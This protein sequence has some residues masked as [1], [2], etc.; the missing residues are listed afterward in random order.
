[1]FYLSSLNLLQYG[2]K[3]LYM[4]RQDLKSGLYIH[5]IDVD[6]VPF[7]TPKRQNRWKA[8]HRS[9]LTSWTRKR[10]LFVGY[11]CMLLYYYILIEDGKQTILKVCKPQ[12]LELIPLSQIRKFLR[13]TSPSFLHDFKLCTNFN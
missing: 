12:I 1:M 5:H 9:S 10:W 7:F 4:L 2:A 13:Y 8:K 11:D 3:V 6:I